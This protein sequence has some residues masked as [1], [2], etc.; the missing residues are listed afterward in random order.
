MNPARRS[1]RDVLFACSAP[2]AMS[3]SL[4][5]DF[6]DWDAT[7]TPMH[8]GANGDWEV[9]VRLARGAHEYKY[10]VDGEWC[11]TPGVGD[12][13]LAGDDVVPN[14]FGTS[15]RIVVVR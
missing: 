2:H 3:V 12:S 5:G 15:N 10:V 8:R 14:R 6:N 1:I 9:R 4:V 13:A 11:C 7:S